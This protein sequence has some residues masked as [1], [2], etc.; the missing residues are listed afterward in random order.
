MKNSYLL[1]FVF[2]TLWINV[3]EVFRYF[4]I[5]MPKTR[6]FLHMVPNVVEMNLPIFAIWGVWDT[7][8][9]LNV[10]VVS[11][12]VWKSSGFNFRSVMIS[13]TVLWA[14]FFVLFWVGMVNMN[15]ATLSLLLIAL[16]LCYIE[17]VVAS[18]IF[19]KTID[20]I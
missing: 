13:G 18:W 2:T 20:Q 6:E 1:G 16:P 4:A 19:M 5:V 10:V 9:T 11:Y 8:L 3:S 17:M 12:Y 14:H 7:V 15:L